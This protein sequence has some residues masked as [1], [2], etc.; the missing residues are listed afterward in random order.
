MGRDENLVREINLRWIDARNLLS[1]LRLDPLIVDEK[2]KRLL[3]LD[4]VGCLEFYLEVRHSVN[5]SRE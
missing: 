2:A 1:L 5:G 3:V 4:A